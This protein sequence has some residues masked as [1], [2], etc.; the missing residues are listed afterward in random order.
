MAYSVQ[1]RRDRGRPLSTE[2]NQNVTAA[3]RTKE[4]ID[5]MYK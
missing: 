3:I 2:V 5:S 4:G 1:A